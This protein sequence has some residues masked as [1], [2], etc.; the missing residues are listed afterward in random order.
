MK[1]TVVLLKSSCCYHGSENSLVQFSSKPTSDR[2]LVIANTLFSEVASVFSQIG[3]GNLQNQAGC[4][5]SAKAENLDL[6][7]LTRQLTISE[8]HGLHRVLEL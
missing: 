4:R 3:G 5:C 2:V 7:K 6:N 1:T 8:T